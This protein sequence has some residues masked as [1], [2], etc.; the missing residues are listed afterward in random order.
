MF[1]RN[2]NIFTKYLIGVAGV[3]GKTR[4]ANYLCYQT[5]EIEIVLLTRNCEFLPPK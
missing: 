3:A 1:L 4:K 2:V 5:V